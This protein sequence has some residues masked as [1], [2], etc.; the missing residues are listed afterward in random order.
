[1][2]D[3]VLRYFKEIEVNAWPRWKWWCAFA[4]QGV[5]YAAMWHMAR[6]F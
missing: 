1:M 4:L 2:I 3:R 6:S 5:S